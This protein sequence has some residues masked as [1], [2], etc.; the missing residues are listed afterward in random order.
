M[1]SPTPGSSPSRRSAPALL[2][3]IWLIVTLDPDD[4]E[5]CLQRFR[6]NCTTG[7]IVFAGLVADGDSGQVLK[8][9]VVLSGGQ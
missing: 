1:C 9:G 8:A 6:A 2:H 5:N 4:P 7:W 3:A